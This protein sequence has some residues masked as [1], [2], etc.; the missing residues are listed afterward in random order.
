MP[1]SITENR[2]YYFLSIQEKRLALPNQIKYKYKVI[3]A[4][5]NTGYLTNRRPSGTISISL[6]LYKSPTA[7]LKTF[8][9]T[10][11]IA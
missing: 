7:F 11:N 3:S 4:I 2:H 6:R 5:N 9:L 1:V 10:P 8:L